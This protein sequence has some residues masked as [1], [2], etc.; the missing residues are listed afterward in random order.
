MAGISNAGWYGWVVWAFS[1][2][3]RWKYPDEKLCPAARL[4]LPLPCMAVTANNHI[5]KSPQ[6]RIKYEYNTTLYI[7]GCGLQVRL[8]WQL[9]WTGYV[10]VRNICN[11]M[12][13][14][15]SFNFLWC[16]IISSP[17]QWLLTS[18]A[19]SQCQVWWWWRNLISQ[20]QSAENTRTTNI[21]TLSGLSLT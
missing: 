9:D 18:Q 11:K 5:A 10:T 4:P 6:I 16:I 3:Y 12:K 13:Y 20:G 2:L 8:L 17:L 21:S 14:C 19:V 7:S 1:V 15:L